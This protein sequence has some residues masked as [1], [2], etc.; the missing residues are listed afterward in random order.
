[1]SEQSSD[2][3]DVIHLGGE[4]GVVVPMHEYRTLKALADRA[5]AEEIDQAETDAAIVE[6]EDW[7]A[8][9]RPG[10]LTHEQAMARLLTGK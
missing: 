8:A 3:H 6:Y 1:M 7:V 10:E 5:S 4:T 2:D 9:G